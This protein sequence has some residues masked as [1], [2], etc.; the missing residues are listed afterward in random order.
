MAKVSRPIIYLVV[1]GAIAYAAVVFTEQEPP[2]KKVA[3]TR[4]TASGPKAPPGF[5]AADM[6]ASFPRYNGKDRDAFAPKIV[7]RKRTAEAIAGGMAPPLPPGLATGI[8]ILTGISSVDGVQSALVE[9][10]STGET[11]FLK[12]GDLWS[13]MVVKE[14]EPEGVILVNAQGKSTRLVFAKPPEEE[15]AAAGS[16][17]PVV[18]PAP[19]GGTVILPGTRAGSDGRAT[20]PSGNPTPMV[21]QR[22]PAVS[23]SPVA[24]APNAPGRPRNVNE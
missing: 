17:P 16:V 9:N 10:G 21:S 22:T 12:T 4:T 23:G 13:G 1:V 3:N 14:I 6:T 2:R 20:P 19:R 11:V 7:A 15:S 18:L 8:W 5:T 24:G